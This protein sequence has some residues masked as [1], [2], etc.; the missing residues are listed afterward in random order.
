MDRRG[1]LRMLGLGAVAAAAPKV[2]YSFLG[3]ILRPRQT[4][5][6][7]QILT[8][9]DVAR[10]CQND[11]YIRQYVEHLANPPWIGMLDDIPWMGD[12]VVN[13]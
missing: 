8:I 10:R 13:G 2:S 7:P 11:K 3:G 5:L 12:P 4:V 9:L 1:F 6:Q